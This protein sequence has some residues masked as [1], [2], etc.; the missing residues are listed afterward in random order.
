VVA[1]ATADHSFVQTYR[2]FCAPGN[3]SMDRRS[4]CLKCQAGSISS[5][6]SKSV[7][8]YSLDQSV[9][10]PHSVRYPLRM[11]A[12]AVFLECRICDGG[13]F[14]TTSS[15]ACS[16]CPR[17]TYSFSGAPACHQVDYLYFGAITP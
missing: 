17:G 6:A 11:R 4:P 15:S 14:S 1:G 3:H 8:L 9:V 7:Q 16:T 12:S 2:A 10:H 13:S 5:L